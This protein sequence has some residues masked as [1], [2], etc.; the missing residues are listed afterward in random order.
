MLYLL[1]HP[2]LQSLHS[3]TDSAF[4][5]GYYQS[6]HEALCGV[7]SVKLLFIFHIWHILFV[8]I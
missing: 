3:Q 4:L 7:I 1:D 2:W 8:I 5:I 6:P